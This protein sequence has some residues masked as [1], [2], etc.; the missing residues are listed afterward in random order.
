MNIIEVTTKPNGMG[1]SWL[2]IGTA[3]AV[4][5]EIGTKQVAW[6]VD[7]SMR[8]PHQDARL[9]V[10][11]QYNKS[12]NSQ[13]ITWKIGVPDGYPLFIRYVSGDKRFKSEMLYKPAKLAEA[14]A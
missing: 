8:Y 13:T 14:G 6:T 10:E 11:R 5:S 7:L 9:T 4:V 2:E 3:K 12:G 1:Q